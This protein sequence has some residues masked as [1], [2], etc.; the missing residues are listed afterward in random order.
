MMHL[1]GNIG[2]GHTRYPTAGSYNYEEAQPFYVNSPYG[3]VL[4]HNGNIVNVEQLRSEIFEESIDR[5]TEFGEGRNE[6][7]SSKKH[8]RINCGWTINNYNSTFLVYIIII[9]VSSRPINIRWQHT[10]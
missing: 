10:L 9:A 6:T 1:E 7:G 3:I 5:Q 2:I 4:V 8:G